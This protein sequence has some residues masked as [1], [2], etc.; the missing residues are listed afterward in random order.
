MAVANVGCTIRISYIYNATYVSTNITAVIA[1]NNS[2]SEC[3]CYGFLSTVPSLYAGMN[4]Y[5]NNKTCALFASYLSLSAIK[6]DLNSIFIFIQQPLSQNTTTA[7]STISP[8]ATSSPTL[9]TG[10]STTSPTTTSTTAS[11]M[12]SPT[13]VIST[14]A[15]STTSLLTT[16]TTVSTT[17]APCINRFPTQV[18]Y[19]TGNGS[20]PYPVTVGDVS[21]DGKPDIIVTNYKIGTVGVL[22]NAGNG[23]FLAQVAYPTGTTYDTWSVSLADMNGDS[24]L[25]IVVGNAAS[26]NIG[27]LLNTG[28]GTFGAQVTYSTGS[29]SHPYSVVAVDVNGD[30]KPDIIAANYY[31]GNIGVFLNTGNGTFG[32]PVT[33]S[34]G[35]SPFSITTADVNGDGKPDIIVAN[36]G[37][38]NV[39]VLFNIGNATFGAQVTYSTGNGSEPYSV[40]AIDVNGDNKPDIITANYNAFNV[41]VFLNTG[42]GTFVAQVTYSTGASSYPYYVSAGDV[43]GDSYADIVVANYWADNVGILLNMGN[44]TFTVQVAYSTGSWSEPYSV[45]VADVNADGTLDIIAGNY[46]ADN[47]GVFLSNCG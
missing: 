12:P 39:G 22:L 14:T 35:S 5:T 7:A 19:S 13:T 29:G 16:S 44:G 15:I 21:G 30:S 3:I 23:T 11:T 20:G 28:N 6:I 4:C 36:T 32:A 9:T 18:T 31:L 1:Y 33:Y 38:D 47:I 8:S 26:N 24:K 10:T 17:T 37:S 25:D 27:I 46:Y 45:R 34:V 42:N 43:N 41:G 40:V 2:C